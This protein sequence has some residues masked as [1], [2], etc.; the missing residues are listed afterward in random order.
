M[1]VMTF[2]DY[3]RELRGKHSPQI[4]QEQLGIAIGRTKMTISQFESG[5]N[6]PPCGELL[7][8]ISDE[9]KLS[10]EERDRLYFLSSF[11]RKSIPLDIEQYFFENPSICKVIRAGKEMSMNDLF[12]ENLSERIRDHNV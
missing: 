1:A 2:G 5:K 4:T 12:W 8:K 6:A 11:E 9:L 3:L 7:E 10:T